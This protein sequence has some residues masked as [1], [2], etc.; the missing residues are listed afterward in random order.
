MKSIQA[1]ARE[2]SLNCFSGMWKM[3]LW[4][5]NYVRSISIMLARPKIVELNG[6]ST[7][8]GASMEES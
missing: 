3:I 4:P 7:I 8:S 1:L 6:A 5:G 2:F